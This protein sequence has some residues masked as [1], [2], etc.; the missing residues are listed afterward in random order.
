M[1]PAGGTFSII[2][3]DSS[4]GAQTFIRQYL[5]GLVNNGLDFVDLTG[6]SRDE[7]TQHAYKCRHL[8]INYYVRAFVDSDVPVEARRN[9][10]YLIF[11]EPTALSLFV[12]RANNDIDNE[13]KAT[14]L[15]DVIYHMMRS[16]GTVA[17]YDR[18]TSSFTTTSTDIRAPAE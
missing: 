3:G 17:V 1:P 18:Y 4:S 12:H 6:S 16:P 15:F 11:M 8:N 5:D 14:N 2:I 9:A 7:M 13:V 10:R